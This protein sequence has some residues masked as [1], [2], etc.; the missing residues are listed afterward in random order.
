[1]LLQGEG[2]SYKFNKH[3]FGAS[4]AS[5]CMACL[6]FTNNFDMLF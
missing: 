5:S 2:K 4:Q 6:V 1:M 3:C